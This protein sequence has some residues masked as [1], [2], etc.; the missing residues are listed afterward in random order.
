M[1]ELITPILSDL[2][3]ELVDLHIAGGPRHPMVRAF[4][5]KQGGVTVEDCAAVSR[6]Y[7]VELDH[8]DL[9]AASYTLEVSS[10]GL[11][12]RLVTPED[13]RRKQGREVWV[14]LKDAKTP[15]E[16]VIVS[17]EHALVLQTPAGTEQ[18]DFERID[19]GLLQI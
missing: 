17:A 7:A 11:D 12:R 4:V 1:V 14:R 8:A 13:F 15:V 6:R 5:D 3:L 18:I 2:S 19:Q 9:I 10:P 16:G